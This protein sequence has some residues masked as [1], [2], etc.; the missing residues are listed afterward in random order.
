MSKGA[1]WYEQGKRV[2]RLRRV[3]KVLPSGCK[4]HLYYD[5][6][7]LTITPNVPT[8][9]Y[10]AKQYSVW[11]KPYGLLSQGSK[12]G[13]HCTLIR[14]AETTLTP[15][16]Q[17]FVVHRLDRAAQ[18]LMVIAHGKSA[19]ATLSAQFQDRKTSKRYH[20]L[21]AGEFSDQPVS[22]IEPID[23][24]AA[25]SHF[26]RLRYN[27]SNN[28]SLLAVDIETGRK[29]QIRKHA[30][31]LGHPII[32]DRLYGNVDNNETRNLQ[33]VSVNLGFDCPINGERKLFVLEP[34]LLEEGLAE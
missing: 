29:H 25:S 1:V 14:H 19:A 23:G 32:G 24:K 7:V 16:R 2:Q 17:A 33:L 20:L 8:L 22:C 28:E 13:D 26:E 11:Y 31:F 21:V 34:P 9:I 10:D 12:W 5:E 30:Q 15:Q 4:L 18:G 3:K 27:A 6:H